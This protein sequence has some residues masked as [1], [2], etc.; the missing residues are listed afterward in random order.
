[1]SVLVFPNVMGGN[2]DLM[3]AG[4]SVDNAASG[5]SARTDSV[6]VSLTARTRTVAPTVATGC[7]VTVQTGM[8]CILAV[9]IS[10]AT[11]RLNAMVWNAA[12]TPAEANVESAILRLSVQR[13]TVFASP[14]VRPRNVA[15]TVAVAIAV[16]VM[17]TRAKSAPMTSSVSAF[18]IAWARSVGSMGAKETAANV[19]HPWFALKEPVRSGSELKAAISCE[20]R[21]STK[22]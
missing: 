16:S 21:R 6:S 14:I 13:E 1:V 5:I 8:E 17:L 9:L 4:V 3:V 12:R 18:R 19:W 7:V 20:K 10:S 15:Q 11:A 22:T 2:V